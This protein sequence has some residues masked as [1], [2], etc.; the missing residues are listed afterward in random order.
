[1][2]VPAVGPQ[3]AL[4]DVLLHQRSA[5]FSCQIS[6][7]S[8]ASSMTLAVVVS[9]T[10]LTETWPPVAIAHSL[11][12]ASVMAAVEPAIT[13]VLFGEGVG[14]CTLGTGLVAVP[15]VG[16]QVALADV[17][18]HQRSAAFSCQISPFSYASSMTLAVV[19]SATPLTETWPPVVIAHSLPDASVMA[20]VE[21]AITTVLLGEGVGGGGDGGR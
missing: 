15:A 20:A 9:A 12:D 16:P 1:M 17:L 7:F 3:V 4:A 2:A 5:A 10:P 14:V 13:T 6:P 8:Y 18:L 11:P 19:V 21:P